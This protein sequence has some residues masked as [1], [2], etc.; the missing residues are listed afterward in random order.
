[1]LDT[2]RG[3]DGTSQATDE[4]GGVFTPDGRTVVYISKRD[5]QFDLFSIDLQTGVDIV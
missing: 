5:G 2:D 3:F 4:A 1:M